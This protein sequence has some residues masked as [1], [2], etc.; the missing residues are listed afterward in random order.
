MMCG[1]PRRLRLMADV[2]NLAIV[3]VVILSFQVLDCFAGV[4]SV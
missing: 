3:D 1:F 2:F 4:S